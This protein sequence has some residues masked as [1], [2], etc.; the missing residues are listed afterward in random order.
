MWLGQWDG[1]LQ[2]D[3]LLAKLPLFDRGRAIGNLA[4]SRGGFRPA[5]L[6]GLGG[7][8]VSYT[9]NVGGR[10][11]ENGE[12]L[13]EDFARN[14]P[15]R[16]HWHPQHNRGPRGS[17]GRGSFKD[18]RQGR[19]GGSTI[20]PNEACQGRGHGSCGEAAVGTCALPS[21]PGRM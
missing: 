11:G 17:V 6:F 1:R 13:G 20:R 15:T 2:V 14:V 19:S 9:S 5:L 4:A 12:D 10:E 18:F 3:G 8:G 16:P 21:L 7:G